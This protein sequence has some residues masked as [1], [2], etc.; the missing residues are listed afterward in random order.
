M[1][2]QSPVRLFDG[3]PSLAERTDSEEEGESSEEDGPPSDDDGG[4]GGG[5]PIHSES[6]V[7]EELATLWRAA[8]PQLSADLRSNSASWSDK[9]EDD[10]LAAQGFGAPS[11][12]RGSAGS[13][14]GDRT[15]KL[16]SAG[17]PRRLKRRTQVTC[18]PHDETR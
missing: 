9:G 5:T 11:N 13:V 15:S 16:N 14:P 4:G 6:E 18:F 8:G 7:D 10:E 1:R 12:K 3:T 17:A 2:P